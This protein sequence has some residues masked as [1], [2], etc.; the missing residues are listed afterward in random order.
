MWC[1]L[2]DPGRV[3]RGGGGWVWGLFGP[4]DAPGARGGGDE[5]V[6]AAF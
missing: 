4:A 3:Q 5:R 1:V 2:E 6:K